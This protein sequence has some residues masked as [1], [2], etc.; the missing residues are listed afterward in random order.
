M[1]VGSSDELMQIE[2]DWHCRASTR[3][4]AWIVPGGCHIFPLLYFVVCPHVEICRVP[5]QDGGLGRP[6]N[7]KEERASGSETF[8]TYDHDS[9]AGADSMSILYTISER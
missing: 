9:E 5:C 8:R 7:S 6:P 1:I 3:Q 2:N 4:I